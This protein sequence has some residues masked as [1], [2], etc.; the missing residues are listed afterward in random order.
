MGMLEKGLKGLRRGG[1]QVWASQERVL[2]FNSL[3]HELLKS[4]V[5]DSPVQKGSLDGAE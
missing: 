2:D 3:F 1:G 5:K 4:T